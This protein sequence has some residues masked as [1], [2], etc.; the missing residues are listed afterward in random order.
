M[1]KQQKKDEPVSEQRA[2]S[3]AIGGPPT[4]SGVAY[5]VHYAVV[6]ALTLLE[7]YLAASALPQFSPM[8]TMEPRIEDNNGLVRWDIRI[9]SP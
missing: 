8:I 2:V 4:A 3:G 1:A 7:E 9:P 6:R 5:Q